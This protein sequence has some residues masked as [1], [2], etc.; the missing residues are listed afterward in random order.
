MSINPRKYAFPM[1]QGSVPGMLLRDYF[2]IEALAGLLA[3]PSTKLQ[4]ND[5]VRAIAEFSY[6]LA[7][8][9]VKARQTTGEK[10]EEA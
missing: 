8:A 3:N 6:D 5:E 1:Q 7:D 2:A 4:D 10:Q 9:M